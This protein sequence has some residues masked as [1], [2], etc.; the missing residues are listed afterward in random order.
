MYIK[1]SSTRSHPAVILQIVV[2][3]NAANDVL[4]R[5]GRVNQLCLPVLCLAHNQSE[6]AGAR[7]G[8]EGEE[9]LDGLKTETVGFYRRWGWSRRG[10]DT[11][12]IRRELML[13]G[14]HKGAL[15]NEQLFVGLVGVQQ[16]GHLPPPPKSHFTPSLEPFCLLFSVSYYCVSLHVFRKFEGA[17]CNFLQVCKKQQERAVFV[18]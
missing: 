8:E 12:G 16:A 1:V 2:V 11:R 6:L 4:V 15:R 10:M 18:S 17:Q 13:V 5:N 3:I 14:G 7:S 9:G